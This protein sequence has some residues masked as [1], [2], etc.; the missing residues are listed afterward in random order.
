MEGSQETPGVGA[1]IHAWTVSSWHLTEAG[2]QWT[3]VTVQTM[4]KVPVK[5]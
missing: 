5:Q 3:F 1:G 2:P 4:E